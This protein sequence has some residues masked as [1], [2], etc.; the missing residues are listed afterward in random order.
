MSTLSHQPHSD[1]EISQIEALTADYRGGTLARRDFLVRLA[2]V[3]G[4]VAAAHLLLEKN[5]LAQVMSQQ[6]AA[7]AKITAADVTFPSGELQTKGYLA[8]P[9]GAGPFP[10]VVVIHENRGLNEHTRDVARRFAGQ[11]FVALAIDLLS[12]RGG[13]SSMA[14]P[15]EARTAIGTIS[16]A[17]AL[18]DLEAS[19]VYLDTLP[20]V[21]KGK[22]ASVGFC[23][24]GARSWALATQSEKLKAAV[25]FYGSAPATEQLVQVKVP[26]L[27]LYGETD[28]RITSLVPEVDQAMKAAGKSF[29]FK[30]YE[31]AG[32]A[33]FNDTSPDR[34]N[35]VAAAD[36][37]TRTLAFLRAKLA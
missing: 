14:T 19:L 1:R 12:R 30:I 36:A 25:V 17:D 9:Q 26:I 10:A 28:T 27:G 33:F 35:A 24:G 3:T 2:A 34:F 15:D 6:E 5:G 32:H 20:A 8:T 29:E 11:G 31:G 18:A 13:T 37:W 21:Q 16:A 22:L 7:A 4:S 23:W